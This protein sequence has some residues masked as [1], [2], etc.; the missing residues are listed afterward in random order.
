MCSCICRSIFSS[1]SSYLCPLLGSVA[2]VL[3]SLFLARGL[4]GTLH[5][6]IYQFQLT[7]CQR[8]RPRLLVL[9][10]EVLPK[11]HYRQLWPQQLDLQNSAPPPIV[12]KLKILAGII[13][14]DS[15]SCPP[16]RQ[17][18]FTAKFNWYTVFYQ[19]P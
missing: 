5:F 11:R 18:L 9:L 19:I 1:V 7:F 13:I 8:N 2:I 10:L 3:S 4:L 12:A 15:K 16:N 6:K 14:G 17:I